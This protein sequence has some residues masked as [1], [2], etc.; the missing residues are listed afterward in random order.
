M[1]LVNDKIDKT[2]NNSQLDVFAVR[3]VQESNIKNFNTVH[4]ELDIL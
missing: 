1:Q 2:N 4:M 3:T